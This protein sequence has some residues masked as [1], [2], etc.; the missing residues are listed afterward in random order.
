HGTWRAGWSGRTGFAAFTDN[1][2]FFAAK[3]IDQTTYFRIRKMTEFVRIFQKT[4]SFQ[5][6]KKNLP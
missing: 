5:T 3:L 6:V 4:T 1:T 2:A